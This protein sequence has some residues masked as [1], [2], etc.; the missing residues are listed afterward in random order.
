MP[1]FLIE[2]PHT[3]EECLIAGEQWLELDGPRKQEIFDKTHASCEFGEH[4]AWVIA[5][6]ETEDEAWSYVPEVER[7]KA[8]IRQVKTYAFEE[9]LAAHR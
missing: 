8:K 1:T 7:L 9:M 3:P 4:N 5:D 6:Y 2:T